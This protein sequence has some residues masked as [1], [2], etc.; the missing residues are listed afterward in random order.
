VCCWSKISTTSYEAL[1]ANPSEESAK[2]YKFLGVPYED[3]MLHIRKRRELKQRGLDAKKVP[4]PVTWGLE[5]WRTQMPRS[6]IERFEAAVGALFIGVSSYLLYR[7][8]V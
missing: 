7:L 5:A 4:Q 6:N 2:L 1:F 3:P 8:I